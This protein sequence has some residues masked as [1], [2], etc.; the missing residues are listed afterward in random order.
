MPVLTCSFVGDV[1]KGMNGGQSQMPF[2]AAAGA[3]YAELISVSAFVVVF[4]S[5]SLT[6]DSQKFGPTG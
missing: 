2:K 5:P 1:L 6:K 4:L 3:H